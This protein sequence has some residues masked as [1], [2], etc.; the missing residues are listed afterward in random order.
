MLKAE[1]I[2][3]LECQVKE[4]ESKTTKD[5]KKQ[6]KENNKIK[7]PMCPRTKKQTLSVPHRSDIHPFGVSLRD[8]RSPLVPF[9][10]TTLRSSRPTRF[11]FCSM[12][13]FSRFHTLRPLYIHPFIHSFSSPVSIDFLSR[14]CLEIGIPIGS[15]I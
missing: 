13:S 9:F 4:S 2:V 3:Q 10:G 8:T 6:P 11:H 14:L 7:Q 5:G 1:R 12:L 15:I